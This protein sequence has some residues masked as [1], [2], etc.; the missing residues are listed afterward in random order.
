ME[1]LGWIGHA[2]FFPNFPDSYALP[3]RAI[4]KAHYLDVCMKNKSVKIEK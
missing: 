1:F 3:N 2:S 4:L